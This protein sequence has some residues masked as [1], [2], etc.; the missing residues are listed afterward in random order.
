MCQES[1]VVWNIISGALEKIEKAVFE[2]VLVYNIRVDLLYFVVLG[3]LAVANKH[4]KSYGVVRH[5]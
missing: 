5:A 1:L 3:I 4:R 2:H